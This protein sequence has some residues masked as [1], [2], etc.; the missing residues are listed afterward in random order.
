MS[1]VL[2]T[3]VMGFIMLFMQFVYTLHMCNLWHAHARAMWKYINNQKKYITWENSHDTL[4]SMSHVPRDACRSCYPVARLL[5]SETC[6][7]F[8]WE[9]F[10]QI[11][12]TLHFPGLIFS[13]KS[14]WHLPNA[15]DSHSLFSQCSPIAAIIMLIIRGWCV[16]FTTKLFLHP[17]THR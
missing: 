13:L 7:S 9:N 2:L 1:V 6:V 5:L 4:T 15:A 10:F 8:A 3:E 12:K 17:S 14:M 16:W 11:G